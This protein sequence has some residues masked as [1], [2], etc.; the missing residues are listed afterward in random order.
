VP[1]PGYFADEDEGDEAQNPRPGGR[2]RG[3]GDGTQKD[4]IDA[5]EAGG[6]APGGSDS[7]GAGRGSP[8]GSP[9]GS[10]R[11]SGTAQGSRKGSILAD[12]APLRI[13]VPFEMTVVCSRA[14]VIIHPGGY[15]L[16]P[17][18][19]K[20]KDRMLVKELNAV[21]QQRRE[22]D[23][24]IIPRPRLRFLVEP[25]GAQSY[26]DAR[27]QTALAGLAWPTTIQVGETSVISFSG[28][29]TTR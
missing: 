17:A 28:R 11:G 16:S 12:K 13:E 22:V 1:P 2:V 4:E 3:A 14:G 20:S 6:G 5:G 27:K 7:D 21:L 15:R 19:L 24:L 10:G 26:E 8:G 18:S 25:G 23:P 29:E 9:G